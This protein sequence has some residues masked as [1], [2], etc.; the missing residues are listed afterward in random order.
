MAWTTVLLL[1]ALLGRRLAHVPGQRS[2]TMPSRAPVARGR[3][4]CAAP[5]VID[6]PPPPP[7][8]FPPGELL[9]RLR[10][11]AAAGASPLD[12][13]PRCFPYALDGFQL[14]AMRALHEGRSV[15]VSAPTGSGKTAIAEVG[16]YAAL[17]RGERAIYTTPLK[18]LSNQ[19][20][21]DLQRVL[22]PESVGLLTGDSQAR[23]RPL[24][25]HRPRLYHPAL[26]RNRS[27][28]GLAG[29]IRAHR[30]RHALGHIWIFPLARIRSREKAAG[31]RTALA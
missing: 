13:L 15:V 25:R 30:R 11:G 26:A 27:C 22:G 4:R 14:D 23:N 18:A 10:D 19:K 31:V 6:E 5:A 2:V 24:P 9:Q 29:A 7:P 8:P 17:A 28:D 1:P 21:G 16:L 20:F 3:A 12:L